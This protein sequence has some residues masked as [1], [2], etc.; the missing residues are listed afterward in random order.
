MWKPLTL[1]P[2]GQTPSS[3]ANLRQNK[4]FLFT[5]IKYIYFLKLVSLQRDRKFKNY[6]KTALNVAFL[7]VSFSWKS[8]RSI[9]IVKC[10]ELLSEFELFWERKVFLQTDGRQVWI[11][12][13]GSSN[14]AWMN[15]FT[16]SQNDFCTTVE[17]SFFI[18]DLVAWENV[19]VKIW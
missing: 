9:S 18:F 6:R 17:Q 5:M 12:Y 11:I 8:Y 14:C 10:K 19:P 4:Y 3:L 1:L 13:L 16:N 2:H 15:L 7:T